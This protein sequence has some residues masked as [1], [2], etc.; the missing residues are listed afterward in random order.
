MAR[1][2]MKAKHGF[3]AIREIINDFVWSDITTYSISEAQTKS[4]WVS[5]YKVSSMTRPK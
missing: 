3:K 1:G 2:L 5:Q 4:T